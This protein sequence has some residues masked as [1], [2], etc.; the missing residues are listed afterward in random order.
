MASRAML[1]LLDA[2]AGGCRRRADRVRMLLSARLVTTLDE[3]PVTLRD[4][5]TTGAMVEASR[6]PAQGLDALLR[7]ARF[8]I[9]STVVWVDG[10]RAGLEFETPLA[11]E[12]FITRFTRTTWAPQTPAS[13]HM[14]RP[15]LAPEPMTAADWES[16][17][18][19]G[20]PVGRDAYRD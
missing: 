8:E 15:T 17:R 20:F 10:R 12:D 6:L 19:W 9:F 4:I 7:R 1:D 5:S 3:F 14:G 11:A 18:A 13:I 2:G 16:V